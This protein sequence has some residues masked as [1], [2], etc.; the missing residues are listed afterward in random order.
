MSATGMAWLVGSKFVVGYVKI[1][2]E[3]EE[4]R[5]Q[6]AAI[7]ESSEDT[8]IGMS[9]DGTVT[10]WNEGAESMYGFVSEEMIGQSIYRLIPETH[11]SEVAE[12]LEIVKHGRGINRYESSRLRKDGQLFDV[13][14]SLSPIRDLQGNV[15]GAA[16]ITRD[17]TL[18]RKGAEQLL[19]YA[20][21]LETLNRVSQEIA[22][23]L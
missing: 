1:R 16:T 7:V 14:A 11:H 8:I 19:A 13:S 10:S 18:L 17:A 3:A 21:Q 5:L 20:G 2:A 22:G 23:T 12:L 15:V 4:A 9:L 6:L